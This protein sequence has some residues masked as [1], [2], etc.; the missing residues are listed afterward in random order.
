MNKGKKAKTSKVKDGLYKRGN[1]WCIHCKING[2]VVR[3]AIGPDKRQAELAL[4]EIKKQR[5]LSKL[6][7]DFSGL[8]SLFAKKT[9]RSFAE[10]AAVYLEER[11]HLKPS[12]IRGY[13]EILTNYLLPVFGKMHVDKITEEHIAKFQ[14]EVSKSVS[15]TRT[16]N[17]MGPLRY[18]L[19][20][21]QRRKL[22]RDNPALCVDPLREEEPN[23]DPL[24]AEELDRAIAA[25]RPYQR[26]LFTCLAWTGARPDELF[27]LRWHDV[28]FER[29]EISISK[30][31]VRGK[32]G[33]PKTKSSK[34]II[35]MVSIVRE[36]LIE[37]RKSAT[38]HVEGYVFLTKS[39]QPY[40]KH[41][42]REWRTALKKSGVR[43]RPAYQLRHTFASLCLQNGLQPTW[44]AKM[45]GHSTPQI[46][47]KH[48]SRYIQDNT[49]INERKL[50]EYLEAHGK[51][52]F[53]PDKPTESRKRIY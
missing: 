51:L 8:E 17:I 38:Q 2:N 53:P 25:L 36:T 44:V 29:N 46:T 52:A 42:D 26:P 9:T 15:A 37:L 10:M 45:L 39:G 32:E 16:N 20:V 49:L 33:T 18:I 11:P 43:H 12:T 50:E 31:R 40:S 4:A 19:K 13:N 5:S 14:S 7:D 22:I 3:K 35:H 48:Y 6:T 27:A 24:N 21:C 1:T 34:R 28:S 23:I 47:F 41:V 30:G